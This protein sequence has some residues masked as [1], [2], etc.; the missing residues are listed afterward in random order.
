MALTFTKDQT[1]QLFELLGI[2][3]DTD[4]SDVDAILAVI[5]NL[6]SEAVDDT[7][8]PS[9]G[10]AAA[11]RL[12]L[13]AVDTD[14]LSTL[15]ADAAEGRRLTAAAAKQQVETK[16]D[17]A[18][19]KGKI[20]ASRRGHWVNLISADPGMADVLASVPDETAVPMT[21]VGHATEPNL[22]EPAAWFY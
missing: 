19:R 21:E 20:A 5:E 7:A 10:A 3:A 14:T 12:G 16:V 15:R 2:P 18:I 11:K 17:D 22:D 13:E 1:A 4:T 9:A 8:K 6:A